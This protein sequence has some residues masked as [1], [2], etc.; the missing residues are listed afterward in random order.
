M[1]VFMSRLHTCCLRLKEWIIS[2]NFAAWELF[3]SSTWKLKSPVIMKCPAS[4]I[5]CSRKDLNSDRN[6]SQV[7]P[8]DV[9]GGGLYT[10][11]IRTGF[12]TLDTISIYSNDLNCIREICL[13][14]K[15]YM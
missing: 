6:D 4:R 12:E 7:R 3:W 13:N 1:A 8:F 2:K 10:T 14:A 5:I 15:A 9:E 11:I